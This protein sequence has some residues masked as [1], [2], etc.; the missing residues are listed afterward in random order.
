MKADSFR[1]DYSARTDGAPVNVSITVTGSGDGQVSVEG[2]ARVDGTFETN[3]TGFVI[4]HPIEGVAGAA[5]DVVGSDGEP[6]HGSFPER[7]LP[8][9]PFFDIQEIRHGFAG[10]GT[11]HLRF[12]GEVFEMEDQRN[13]TDASF[14][15]YCR[16]LG[17]PYP[18][19]VDPENPVRQGIRLDLSEPRT[20]PTPGGQAVELTLGEDG[21]ETMPDLALAFEPGWEPEDW[22]AVA[23][24]RPAALVSRLDVAE[25]PDEALRAIA[26]A[27]G[28]VGG[29]C[30]LEVVLDDEAD[31]EAALAKL[32]SLCREAGVAPVS[33]MALPRAYLKSHQPSGPWPAGVS[34][35]QAADAARNAFPEARIGGGMLTYFTEFNRCPPS[36][37]SDGFATHATSAI[38]HAADD[39]SVMETL[40]CLPHVF[41]SA[42]ALIGSAGYRLGLVAIGMRSNP[43]GAATKENPEQVRM[44]MAHSDP[45][46]RGLFG[47]AWALGALAATAGLA[48]N[49]SR[50]PHRRARS[51]SSTGQCRWPSPAT[52]PAPGTAHRSST[53]STMSCAGCR[54]AGMHAGSTWPI[55]PRCGSPHWP[56]RATGARQCGSPICR[57]SP[58]RSRSPARAGLAR[59]SNWS[60][61]ED[62]AAAPDWF[63]TAPETQVEG[64]LELGAYASRASGW[65]GSRMGARIRAS[66][67]IE[68]GLDVQAAA[69]VMAG[70]QSSGTFVAIPGETPELRARA[71]ARVEAIEELERVSSPSLPGAA[72]APD[73]TY[74][75]ARVELSWPLENLGPSLPNLVAT[76]A[77]NLFELR[78]FSGLK[79]LDIKLPDAFASAYPGPAFGVEGTRRLAGV[80]KRPLIGTIIK[81]SVGLDAAATADLVDEL[82]AAGID[83]IKDDELRPMAPIAPL[84]R[85]SRR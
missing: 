34:P 5:A 57:P 50:S 51:A 84:R 69:E 44:A 82:C 22:Q 21:G 56:T 83:F 37:G 40:E 23:A 36:P 33:V 29:A 52:R 64:Q 55:P 62:A 35:E 8:G 81:P 75:R 67:L 85:A 47:A 3:R 49:G 26:A 27:H 63:E 65:R 38:V 10:G 16:P 78:Q 66:Y 31:P 42:R 58:R 45:R 18:Y 30:E 39:E 77:G 48:W 4:L 19:A 12:S 80:D 61:L 24:L 17:L 43:Y 68:T 59:S 41:G 74:T 25:R 1:Y 32:A 9:Q 76:V 54:T 73:G 53:R 46:Q 60:N 13:W 6:R 2:E 20:P 28:A 14:K 11:V 72:P 7:I 15:T 71:G 70:E 79:L